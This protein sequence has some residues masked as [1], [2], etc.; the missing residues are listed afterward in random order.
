MY[1]G[2]LVVA[3]MTR[4]PKAAPRAQHEPLTAITNVVLRY[5][6]KGS[7]T[8]N[9]GS[10]VNTYEVVN[11]GDVPCDGQS[12]CSPDGKW[13][14]ALGQF[15]A[16][17]GE[18]NQFRN[19]RLSC[20]AG[21]CPFTRVEANRTTDDGRRLAISILNWSDTT[22]FLM[23]AEVVHTMQNEVVRHA[24]P[25][26]FGRVMSFTV[27]EDAEG[28]SV[29]AELNGTDIVFPMGPDVVLSWATCTVTRSDHTKLYR[30]S[31][32]TGYNFH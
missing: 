1:S 8:V 17:A 20:I 19:P 14:A 11:S 5:T 31:L 12:P 26:I 9:V 24:Y 13:K 15:S 6:A 22:T 21:P 18:N 32:K 4:L 25:A 3:Y 29:E 16:D 28:P 30:C 10:A 7:N 23:E 2:Q 27:P